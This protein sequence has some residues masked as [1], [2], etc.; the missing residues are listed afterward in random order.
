[1]LYSPVVVDA[2]FVGPGFVYSP[3]YAVPDVMVVDAL[4][5]RPAYYHYYFG[6]Y[7][8]PVYG[9]FGFECAFVYSQRHYD[10]IVVYGGWEHRDNP[11]WREAQLNIYIGRGA[12][13]APLPPRTLVEQRIIIA[14]GGPGINAHVMLAARPQGSGRPRH[15]DRR[16]QPGCPCPGKGSRRG[17]PQG[18]GRPSPGHRVGTRRPPPRQRQLRCR[19]TPERP[20]PR[21]PPTTRRPAPPPKAQPVPVHR[22]RPLITKSKGQL[23]TTKRETR[24]ARRRKKA[25]SNRSTRSSKRN[26]KKSNRRLTSNARPMAAA[27]DKFRLCSP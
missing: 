27:A 17:S 15:Q 18:R 2:R 6:D 12:G 1:M 25:N 8:G 4:W 23:T 21:R 22:R 10:A 14:R 5:V 7:Y 9:R 16:P 3:Y 13:R 26:N 11:G 19:T 24:R 20:R